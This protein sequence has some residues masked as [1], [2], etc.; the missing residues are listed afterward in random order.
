LWSALGQ[1]GS[2]ALGSILGGE[3][4]AKRVGAG[5]GAAGAAGA[6]S[7]GSAA[8][9][10]TGAAAAGLTSAAAGTLSGI[11]VMAP[12]TGL[13]WMAPSA[14]LSAPG[15]GGSTG[16]TAAGSGAGLGSAMAAAVPWVVGAAA[17]FALGRLLKPGASGFV[18]SSVQTPEQQIAWLESYFGPNWPLIVGDMGLL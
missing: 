6:A 12:G 10:G 16:A 3:G 14:A 13:P 2:Q 1:L 17:P 5:A 4:R 8:A 7:G 15:V 11:P 9:G 18:D